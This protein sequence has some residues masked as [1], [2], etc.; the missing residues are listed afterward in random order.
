[1]ERNSIGQVIIKESGS[2]LLSI[3]C[4][5]STISVNTY[6]RFLLDEREFTEL[7]PTIDKDALINRL[8]NDVATA[9]KTINVLSS[10]LTQEKINSI[11]GCNVGIRV[12]SSAAATNGTGLSYK[13][14]N[15]IQYQESIGFDIL[16]SKDGVYYNAIQTNGKPVYDINLKGGTLYQD[17]NSAAFYTLKATINY[18]YRYVGLNTINQDNATTKIQ[19][20]KL[21]NNDS[22]K[23]GNGVERVDNIAATYKPGDTTGLYTI[24]LLDIGEPLGGATDFIYLPVITMP[25]NF[26]M[27]IYPGSTFTIIPE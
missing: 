1:M 22:F 2:L 27:E 3:P 8:E 18:R 10:N 19:F 20:H 7:T 6:N 24:N 11:G 12:S 21:T 4:I 13:T 14:Y 5:T 17:A 26:I 16:S 9:T 23:I 25:D 15:G